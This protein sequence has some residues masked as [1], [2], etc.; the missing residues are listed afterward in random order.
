MA[1][2]GNQAAK[3]IAY[4]VIAIRMMWLELSQLVASF[5]QPFTDRF[6]WLAESIL[7]GC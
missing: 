2:N 5:T 7:S 4:R 1:K 3:T 6:G